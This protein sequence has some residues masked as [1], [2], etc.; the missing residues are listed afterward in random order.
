MLSLAGRQEYRDTS[1][2][3]HA[4][5]AAVPDGVRV[6]ELHAFWVHDKLENCAAGRFRFVLLSR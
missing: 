1:T 3:L 4:G 2:A 5:H 6:R